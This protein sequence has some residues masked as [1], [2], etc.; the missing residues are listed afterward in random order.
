MMPAKSP[1]AGYDDSADI[2]DQAEKTAGRYFSDATRTQK[3]TYDAALIRNNDLNWP[4]SPSWERGRD[5]AKAGWVVATAEARVLY[6][7]TIIEL[8]ASG[9]IDD[10]LSEAWTALE[11]GAVKVSEAA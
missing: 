1:F 6:D 11:H 10:E 8:L 3:T 4:L 9:E 7:R 5:A 2:L